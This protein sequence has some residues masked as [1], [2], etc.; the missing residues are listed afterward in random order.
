MFLAGTCAPTMSSR[1]VVEIMVIG[2]KSFSGS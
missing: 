2:W 1:R